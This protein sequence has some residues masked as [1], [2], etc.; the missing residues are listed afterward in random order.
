MENI[1]CVDIVPPQDAKMQIITT[2]VSPGDNYGMDHKLHA[3]ELQCIF[4]WAIDIKTLNNS[5]GI[6]YLNAKKLFLCNLL[7]FR[8]YLS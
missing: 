5:K 8:Y 7:I 4:K 3:I 1:E 6:W 2:V